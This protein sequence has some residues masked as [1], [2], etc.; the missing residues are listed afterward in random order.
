M[1]KLSLTTATLIAILPALACAWMPEMAE[2]SIHSGDS[3][4]NSQPFAAPLVPMAPDRLAGWPAMP[5][6]PFDAM[7]PMDRRGGGHFTPR[8]Q[9]RISRQATDD[10]YLIDIGLENIAPDQV[11]IRPAGSDLIISYSTGMRSRQEATLPRG[12]GVWKSESFTH[13]ATSRRIAFPPDA[14]PGNLSREVSAGHIQV[15][16]PRAPLGRWPWSVR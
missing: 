13:G 9:M 12:A 2:S 16:I 15:R 6:G 5:P 8:S 3:I 7:A 1:H 11:D 14:N 4:P 10:A